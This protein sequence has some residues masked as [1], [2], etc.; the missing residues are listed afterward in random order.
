MPDVVI[1]EDI[2]DAEGHL[3]RTGLDAVLP[4]LRN[5]L[6]H[7]SSLD[8]ASKSQISSHDPRSGVVIFIESDTSTPIP[9][10]LFHLHIEQSATHI[11]ILS[12]PRRANAFIGSNQ[13]QISCLQYGLGECLKIVH[14]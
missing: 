8:W 2:K 6:Y 14:V 10:R 12:G 1:T 13:M 3:V 9:F 7:T 11:S 5:R 4:L